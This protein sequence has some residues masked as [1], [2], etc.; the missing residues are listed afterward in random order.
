MLPLAV[1]S[2]WDEVNYEFAGKM[3]NLDDA[4]VVIEALETMKFLPREIRC[5]DIIEATRHLHK[6]GLLR[7]KYKDTTYFVRYYSYTNC[8]QFQEE[9]KQWQFFPSPFPSYIE[10]LK[11]AQKM[12]QILETLVLLPILI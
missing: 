12:V 6:G 4:L 5:T 11:E 7:Y 3:N 2:S 8:Y 10:N 9:G 1:G